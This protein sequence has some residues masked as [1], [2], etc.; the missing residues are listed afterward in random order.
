[1]LGNSIALMTLA[2]MIASEGRR[3]E[4]YWRPGLYTLATVVALI[5]LT[6]QPIADQAPVV[7]STLSSIFGNPLSWFFLFMGLF[8]VL[9]PFW[10]PRQSASAPTDGS[11]KTSIQLATTASYEKLSNEVVELRNSVGANVE[12]IKASAT[13]ALEK[14]EETL[15]AAHLIQEELGKTEKRM[16]EIELR[17]GDAHRIIEKVEGDLATQR[18]RIASSLHSIYLREKL[19]KLAVEIRKDAADLS[20]KVTE[21][22]QH[23]AESWEKWQNVHGHWWSLMGQWW[24]AARFYLANSRQVLLAPDNMYPRI[25]LDENTL[26]PAG[27]AEAVRV[28]KKFRIIQDQWEA[29]Q[30]QLE[31]NMCL[32]AF[33]GQTELDVRHGQPLEQGQ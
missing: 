28:Y 18:D 29:V 11:K 5:A 31:D 20:H 33:S 7:G 2:L 1:M 3:A 12:K 9:R 4:G 8:F 6:L 24:T 14:G 13:Q 10:Q 16:R 26:V 15:G 30:G 27:G 21:G 32:V 22:Q 17:V 19:A 23:D 25:Q